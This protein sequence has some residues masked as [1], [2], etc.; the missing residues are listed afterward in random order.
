V[1]G[2]RDVS[3]RLTK[4]AMDSP[5]GS[6]ARRALPHSARR[7]LRSAVDLPVMRQLAGDAASQRRLLRMSA[8]SGSG[9]AS[10]RPLPVHLRDLPGREVHMRPGTADVAVVR[11]L[12]MKQPHLPPDTAQLGDVRLVW[13]LGAHIGLAALDYSEHWPSARVVAVELEPHNAAIC[14][15]NLAPLGNRTEVIQAAVWSSDGQVRIAAEPAEAD[16]NAFHAEPSGEGGRA[17]AAM[18]LDTLLARTAGQRAVDLCKLDIEGAERHVLRENT[19][20]AQQVRTLV[21][22]VHDDYTAEDCAHDLRRLG[23]DGV[24]PGRAENIVVGMRAPAPA[25]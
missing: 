16:T 7:A 5:L 12:M 11:D 9:D 23:F 25:R 19:D 13:D 6:A 20:W 24:R 17:V 1:P 2:T 4:L 14:R 10:T 15:L 8:D 21:V 18:S 3:Y 22:E